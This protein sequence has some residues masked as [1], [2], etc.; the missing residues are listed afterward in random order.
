MAKVTQAEITAPAPTPEGL[1]PEGGVRGWLCVLG[2]FLCMFCSFGFLN[3][4][5]TFNVPTLVNSLD[6][7]DKPPQHGRLPKD[8]RRNNTPQLLSI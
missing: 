8:V 4:Y 6:C 1:P 2:S 3:S 7:T 5:A